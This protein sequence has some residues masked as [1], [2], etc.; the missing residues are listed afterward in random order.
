M[1]MVDPMIQELEYELQ[2]TAKLM[3]A[4]PADQWDYKPHEKA[5]TLQQ[6]ASHLVDGIMWAKVTAEMD[7]FEMDSASYSP[8]VDHS[9]EE[10]IARLE[11][12][13]ADSIAAMRALTDEQMMATWTMKVDGNV[14]FSMPRA[15]VLRSMIL[16]HHYHHRG[17]LTTYLRA[18]GAKVPG[19]YGPTADEPVSA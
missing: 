15:A 13:K 8:H 19:M 11:T 16:N 2:N 5:M 17:Q 4:L 18:V 14:V 6:L 9:P 7:L 1:K 10:V 12:V 3:A